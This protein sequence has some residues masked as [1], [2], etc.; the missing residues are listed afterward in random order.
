MIYNRTKGFT[1]IELLVSI[2]I[3]GILITIVTVAVLPIQKKSRDSRRKADLNLLISGLSLFN[4]DYK[5]YPNPTFYL[6][7]FNNSNKAK[8][9]N[10]G[11]AA[12]IVSCNGAQT[13]ATAT[14]MD[15]NGNT[16]AQPGS[17]TINELDTKGIKLAPGFIAVNNF[18]AC[19]KYMDRLVQDPLFVGNDRYQYRISYDYSEFLVGAKLENQNDQSGKLSLFSDG[20]T[21]SSKWFFD[22]NGANARNLDDDTDVSGEYFSYTANNGTLTDGRYFYQCTV[23]GLGA[24]IDEDKR[25][26]FP[27]LINNGSGWTANIGATATACQNNIDANT[28]SRISN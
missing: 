24:S 19:L 23:D 1:L 27:P 22:G 9:S 25:P 2:T 16:I 4:S 26:D 5:V 17:P 6:G 14:F 8:N 21:Y 12:D 10:Y 3:I 13:G 7:S 11:L 15:L 18:L 20:A 28:V